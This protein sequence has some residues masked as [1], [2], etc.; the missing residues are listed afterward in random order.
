MNNFTIIALNIFSE[1]IIF[2]NLRKFVKKIKFVQKNE[3]IHL[4]QKRKILSVHS[5]DKFFVFQFFKQNLALLLCKMIVLRVFR[6][7]DF[8]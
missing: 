2:K 7:V 4:M 8:F 6:I 1:N 5:S 3:Q